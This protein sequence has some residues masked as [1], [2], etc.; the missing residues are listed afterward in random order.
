MNAHDTMI[1]VAPR[2]PDAVR[3]PLSASYA[4]TPARYRDRAVGVG[5]GRS[6]GYGFDKRY[7]RDWG[8]TR[9]RCR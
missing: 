8:S 5:Y 2:A 9:F 6:S 7:T 4:D 1:C 3:L